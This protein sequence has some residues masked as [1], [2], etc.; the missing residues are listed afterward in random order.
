MPCMEPDFFVRPSLAC[1]TTTPGSLQC[2]PPSSQRDHHPGPSRLT[3]FGG[4]GWSCGRSSGRRWL[5]R[6]AGAARCDKTAQDMHSGV[7][8]FNQGYRRSDRDVTRLG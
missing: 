3:I 7:A 5:G 8:H 1:R 6:S 4:R 2:A